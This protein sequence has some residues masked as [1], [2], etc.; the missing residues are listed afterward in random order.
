MKIDH[1]SGENQQATDT[2]QTLGNIPTEYHTAVCVCTVDWATALY[3]S[4]AHMQAMFDNVRNGEYSE[5]VPA[6]K[7]P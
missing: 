2:A 6:S 1:G 7:D 5:K 4:A 3:Q